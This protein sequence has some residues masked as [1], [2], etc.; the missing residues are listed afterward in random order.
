[1]PVVRTDTTEPPADRPGADAR[2]SS[3][4][5]TATQ[6]PRTHHRPLLRIVVVLLL[7]TGT[8]LLLSAILD[9]VHVHRL[10]DLVFRHPKSRADRAGEEVEHQRASAFAFVRRRSIRGRVT[11]IDGN[12]P[13][14]ITHFG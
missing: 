3:V 5:G 6:P 4:A 10:D 14:C 11:I 1:V 7:T 13:A 9:D 12:E 8:L 2:E